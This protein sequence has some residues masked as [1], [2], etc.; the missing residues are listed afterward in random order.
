MSPTP[1]SREDVTKLHLLQP[2]CVDPLTARTRHSRRQMQG[3]IDR[4]R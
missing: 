2:L 3:H 4:G 1:S